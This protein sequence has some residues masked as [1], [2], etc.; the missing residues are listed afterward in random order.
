MRPQMNMVG[1]SCSSMHESLRFWFTNREC[2][3]IQ[4]IRCADWVKHDDLIIIIIPGQEQGLIGYENYHFQFNSLWCGFEWMNIEGTN[5]RGAAR[6]FGTDSSKH[7][8]AGGAATRRK[9]AITK[10]IINIQLAPR[11][12]RLHHLEL[13]RY[14]LYDYCGWLTFSPGNRAIYS[15]WAS[16]RRRNCR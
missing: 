1:H 11:G 13:R 9:N 12:W 3:W 5:T 2:R 6:W 4:R 14:H 10:S 7:P 8:L 16:K 15:C